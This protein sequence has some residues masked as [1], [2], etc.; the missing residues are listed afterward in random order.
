MLDKYKIKQFVHDSIL[1]FRGLAAK[2]AAK[3]GKTEFWISD[4]LKPSGETNGFVYPYLLFMERLAELNPEAHAMIDDE[5][6]RI[7]DELRTQGLSGGTNESTDALFSNVHKSY[8]DLLTTYKNR[9]GRGE[10][11]A[12]AALLGAHIN[13]LVQT[14][15]VPMRDTGTDNVRKIS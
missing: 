11:K 3:Y 1:M 14:L 4:I 6:R 8:I 7:N 5:V 9:C 2:L 12:R 10:I 15:D 13:T